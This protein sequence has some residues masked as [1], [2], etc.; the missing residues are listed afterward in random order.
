MAYLL[1]AKTSNRTEPQVQTHQVN[2]WGPNFRPCDRE[3]RLITFHRLYQGAYCKI[4]KI[5][6]LILT[7]YFKGDAYTTIDFKNNGQSRVNVSY[8]PPSPQM[9]IPYLS[10]IACKWGL[11]SFKERP[12][13]DWSKPSV[14]TYE[15]C[16]NK[17]LNTIRGYLITCFVNIGN[18]QS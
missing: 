13:W 3:I 18:G 10:C 2:E 1:I 4:K 7:V 16:N 14:A 5:S 8:S 12:R 6:F 15:L 9:L 11:T 17:Q